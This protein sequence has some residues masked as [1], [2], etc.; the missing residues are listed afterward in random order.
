MDLTPSKWGKWGMGWGALPSAGVWDRAALGLWGI[1]VH[2]I[3][4]GGWGGSCRAGP[5]V[6]GLVWGSQGS[7]RCSRNVLS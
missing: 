2:P 6:L 5:Q 7:P 1:Q 3:T 4:G